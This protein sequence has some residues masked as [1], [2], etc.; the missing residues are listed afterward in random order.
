M[1]SNTG[2]TPLVYS[3]EHIRVKVYTVTAAAGESQIGLLAY[4]ILWLLKLARFFGKLYKDVN[5]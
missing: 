3:I 5:V 4:G 2:S 1:I